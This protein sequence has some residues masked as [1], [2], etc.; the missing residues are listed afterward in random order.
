CVLYLGISFVGSFTIG[1]ALFRSAWLR[2]GR[3]AHIPS[4][5]GAGFGLGHHNYSSVLA[6]T[7]PSCPD[8]VYHTIDTA[9]AFSY[10]NLAQQHCRS[11]F[12][13]SLSSRSELSA[14]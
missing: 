10:S 12:S 2:S 1:E 7:F 3:S 5:R 6:N 13:C 8:A 4:N 14:C 11:P 9:S